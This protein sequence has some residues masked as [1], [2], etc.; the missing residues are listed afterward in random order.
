MNRLVLFLLLLAPHAAAG[1]VYFR[2]TVRDRAE[3]DL[4]TRVISIDDVRGDTVY[5]YASDREFS[6]FSTLGYAPTIL[7]HP[8]D[9]YEHAMSEA[10]LE[11]TDWDRY[12]TYPGYVAMM[13]NF[14]TLH[15]E[16]CRLDTF[17]QSMLG[18]KLLALKISDNVNVEEDEPEFLYTSTMHGDETV[19]YVLTL[20]LADYLLSLYGEDTPEGQRVTDLVNAVEIWIN[21]NAN[22]DGTYWTSD[23]TVTGARRGNRNGVDLNRDFPDRIAD[24]VNTGAGREVETQAMM[25]FVRKRNFSASA[26]F[27]GGAQVV[28]YPWDNGQP[29]G[30]YSAAPDDAWFIDHSLSYSS[31]NPDLLAG[32]WPNGI[33]NGCQWY[34][35][36]GGRQDWITW[37]HGGR[38]VTIELWNTKNPPG[39]ALPARW[40]NNREGMLRYMEYTLRGIRGIVTDALNGAPLRARVDVLSIPGAPVYTDSVSGNFH[41]LLRPGTYSIRVSSAGYHPDTVRNIAVSGPSATRADVALL[42]TSVPVVRTDE[43]P[44][45]HPCL[46]Q[47]YP[48]PFNPVTHI[49]FRVASGDA[50]GATS[51]AIYD[52]LGRRV[53]TLVNEGVAPGSYMVRFDA[54]GLPSGVYLCRL[55]TGGLVATRRMM[56]L[57]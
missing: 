15:P 10:G 43:I 24:T 8:G 11:L 44:V 6:F 52:L 23:T 49:P 42:P 40:T 27:H 35:V 36:F 47:N 31:T 41:R 28:N 20:R 51:L 7:T 46:E 2:F 39:S 3:L 18:R 29:S 9:E 48:N 19:G 26:N 45:S 16:I 22:P 38:E 5:A 30:S 57:R 37:W 12:P 34:A 21:P 32:G 50:H 55:I 14:A 56:L 53:A 54:T 13:R 25:Q 4:L 17:G 1:E 33:V